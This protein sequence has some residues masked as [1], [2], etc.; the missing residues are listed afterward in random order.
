MRSLKEEPG[1]NLFLVGSP[2]L[3]HASIPEGLIDDFSLNVNPVILG[4]G[5]PP[6]GAQNDRTKLKLVDRR[7]HTNGVLGFHYEL[8]RGDRG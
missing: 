5:I 2:R 7:T 6:F 3:L 1:K 4:A 8:D